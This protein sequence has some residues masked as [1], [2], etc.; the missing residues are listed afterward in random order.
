MFKK[1]G[2]KEQW[3]GV[4]GVRRGVA[5]QCLSGEARI[6]TCFGHRKLKNEKKKEDIH[7][8]YLKEFKMECKN[9]AVN[10][11]GTPPKNGGKRHIRH[12]QRVRMRCR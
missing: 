10:P 6:C 12:M 1:K 11:A 8:N 5:V 3:E 2:N 9:N 7:F 4:K